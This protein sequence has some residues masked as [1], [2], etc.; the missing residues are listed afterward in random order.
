MVEKSTKKSV[1][2]TSVRITNQAYRKILE[3]KQIFIDLGIKRTVHNYEIIDLALDFYLD[4]VKKLKD[5][6][7]KR[8]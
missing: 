4:F 5:F 8:D 6:H 2:T 7:L 1:E 3:I